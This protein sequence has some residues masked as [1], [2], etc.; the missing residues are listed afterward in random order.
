[1]IL[2]LGPRLDQFVIAEG[3]E[4]LDIPRGVVAVKLAI[5]RTQRQSTSVIHTGK[6]RIKPRWI[7]QEDSFKSAKNCLSF[8]WLRRPEYLGLL[9]LLNL[10]ET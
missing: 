8:V 9:H 6:V 10:N 1:M 4:T 2:R 7:F 3:V 5:A